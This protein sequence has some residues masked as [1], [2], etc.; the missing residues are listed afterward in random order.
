MRD[1]FTRELRTLGLPAG[2]GPGVDLSPVTESDLER[3]PDSARRYL[4]FMGVVGR[5]RDWSFRVGFRGRF[6]RSF[7][8]PWMKC[9]AWQYNTRL[10]LARIFYIQIRFF[11]LLPVLGR[12][13]YVNGRGRMT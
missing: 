3:L 10:D 2:P 7:E 8:E 6:R 13:T 5:P 4:R 11:G 12:D 1:R 9:E